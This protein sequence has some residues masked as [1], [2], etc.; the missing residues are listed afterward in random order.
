MSD[1]KKKIANDLIEFLTPK[2]EENCINQMPIDLLSFKFSI[3]LFYSVYCSQFN[4][5]FDDRLF[6]QTINFF[7][8]N[9][10]V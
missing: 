8:V 9:I 2:E 7:S 1:A 10:F 3:N 4:I 5:P 6:T